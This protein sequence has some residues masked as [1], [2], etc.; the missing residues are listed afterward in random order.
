MCQYFKILTLHSTFIVL[1]ASYYIHP[2]PDR[3]II[4]D[5]SSAFCC[6]KRIANSCSSLTFSFPSFLNFLLFFVSAEPVS[7]NITVSSIT[8]SSARVQWPSFPLSFSV[9]YYFVRYKEDSNS[10]S[11]LFRVSGYSNTHYSG[12]LRG[13]TAYDVQV[14]AVTTDKGNATY[15]SNTVSFQTPEGGEYHSL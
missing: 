2:L 7:W 3:R 10:V 5:N 11:R 12:L 1:L 6:N 14:F 13:Y 15:A 4:H 9:S 8:S